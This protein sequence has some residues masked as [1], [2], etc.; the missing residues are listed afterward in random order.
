MS[1][2]KKKNNEFAK[3]KKKGDYITFSM[4]L[5][6]AIEED[7]E[8]NIIPYI[9]TDL[10]ISLFNVIYLNLGA[11]GMFTSEDFYILG[12]VGLG[13]VYDIIP[14]KLYTFAGVGLGIMW[15]LPTSFIMLRLNSKLSKNLSVGL[16][17]KLFNFTEISNDISYNLAIGLN[18][19]HRFN[20]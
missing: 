2:L 19:S 16:D 9:L 7:S 12:Q 15:Q 14:D 11:G 4:G 13:F 1:L 8:N 6:P 18:I 17:T 10:N 3:D 5:F 20:Y